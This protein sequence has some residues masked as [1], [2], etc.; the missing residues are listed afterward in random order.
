MKSDYK[1]IIFKKDVSQI[2][3]IDNNLQSCVSR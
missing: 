3:F 1:G 2:N